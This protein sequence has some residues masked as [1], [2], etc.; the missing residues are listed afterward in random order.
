[1]ELPVPP[2]HPLADPQS[3]P[4]PHLTQ[5]DI[6]R[7]LTA[8]SH[9]SSA[10]THRDRALLELL[11]D[12]GLQ[13]SELAGLN[14]NDVDPDQNTIVCGKGSRQRTL[15]LSQR[16][17]GALA[18]YLAY[19]KARPDNGTEFVAQS[20]QP[21]FLNNRGQ[22]LTRQGI[23]MIVRAHAAAMGMDGRITPR[24]LRHS[25]AARLLQSGVEPREARQRLGIKR[26]AATT[27]S[28]EQQKMPRLLLDGKVAIQ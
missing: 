15:K 26:L 24:T 27:Q 7:L 3:P 16:A 5:T 6:E 10:T 11:C 20:A 28:E 17:A 13:V 2:T 21:L 8:P 23:W 18:D 14:I 9:S 19:D 22:R 25:V 12:T 1:M 4:L